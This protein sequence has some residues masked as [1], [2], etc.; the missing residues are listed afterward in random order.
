M[1]IEIGHL[2]L[3]LALTLSSITLLTSSFGYVNRWENFERLTFNLSSVIFVFL[4]ISFSSLVYGF[5][6]SDFSLIIVFQNS[7][8][9]KP[10]LYKITGK[11]G[12]HEG[13]LLLWVL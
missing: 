4:L 7:H 13:S 5:L 9:S 12:N 11:W 3:L 10:L 6:I 1:I 8:T 2:S